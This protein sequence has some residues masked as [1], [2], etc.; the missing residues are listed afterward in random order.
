MAI[1][2]KYSAASS[3]LP[4]DRHP[5]QRPSLPPL[6]SLNLPTM[7]PRFAPA[8][9][10]LEPPV[11]TTGYGT[12]PT[13]HHPTPYRPR[14]LSVSSCSS[15]D[16][17]PSPSP[18][19]PSCLSISHFSRR[20]EAM[21]R[22]TQSQELRKRLYAGDTVRLV[23]CSLDQADGVLISPPTRSSSPS[24]VQKR[25][26]SPASPTTTLDLATS[27]TSASKRVSLFLTGPTLEHFKRNMDKLEVKHAKV[28]AYKVIRRPA[29][30]AQLRPVSPEMQVK[31]EDVAME[32]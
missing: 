1:C 25:S 21:H 18:P 16:T 19:P 29:G 15:S 14:Q 30:D 9:Q 22:R 8:K 28:L 20:M 31:Q 4:R 10:M 26:P 17:S 27:S 32:L 6:H 7:R 12:A 2:K 23:P 24:F 5:S 13:L 11:F 3:Q